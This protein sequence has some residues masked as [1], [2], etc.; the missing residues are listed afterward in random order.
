MYGRLY[1]ERDLQ[2]AP[3]SRMIDYEFVDG[4]A[5]ATQYR[6]S[7]EHLIHWI[8]NVSEYRKLNPRL[9]SYIQW[10]DK[11]GYYDWMSSHGH[12]DLKEQAA[13]VAMWHEDLSH[14]AKKQKDKQ[15]EADFQSLGEHVDK[16]G[17]VRTYIKKENHFVNKDE[18]WRAT[19]LAAGDTS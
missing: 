13:L 4:I 15:F 9:I 8:L 1:F 17:F 16:E 14:P 10:E 7:K 6:S 11:A 12:P 5:S 2:L 3:E 19:K 18:M